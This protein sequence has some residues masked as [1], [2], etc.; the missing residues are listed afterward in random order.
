MSLVL[1][2]EVTELLESIMH[3]SAPTVEL[4]VTPGFAFS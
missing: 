4:I 3:F 2:K 1:S